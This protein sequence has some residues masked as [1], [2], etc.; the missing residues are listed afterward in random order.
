MLLYFHTFTNLQMLLSSDLLTIWMSLAKQ[1]Q[2]F[3]SVNVT[4]HVAVLYLNSPFCLPFL[5][6]FLLLKSL[7]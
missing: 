4:V 1:T 6:F 7:Q 5:F 3:Q 2:F